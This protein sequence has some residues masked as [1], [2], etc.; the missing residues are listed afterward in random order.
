M[1]GY[2]D[3]NLDFWRFSVCICAMNLDFRHLAPPKRLALAYARR[4]EK[5]AL[6]LLLLFDVSLGHIVQRSNEPLIGQMRLAWWRD[7]MAKPASEMP[8]GE[9]L[10]GHLTVLQ[11][12]HPHWRLNQHMLLIVEGWDAL[13]AHDEWVG[14]VLQSHA[15]ARAQGIFAG[16]ADI[17]GARSDDREQSTTLGI[18]W[19]L[20]DA[21]Q[22]CQT[23]KQARA[24]NAAQIDITKVSLPRP[25]RPLSILAQASSRAVSPAKLFW[26]ALTGR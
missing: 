20:A 3:F 24:I 4:P 10:I 9:P 25:L 2:R 18:H 14:D 17:S 15:K 26:H 16:F 12:R 13:L 19:A 1:L 11:E 23:E 21:L 6:A 22:Y 8:S 5:E 7:V